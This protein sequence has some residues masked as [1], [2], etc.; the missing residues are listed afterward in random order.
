SSLSSR[1]D[2]AHT[3]RLLQDAPAAYRTQ[4][5]DLLLTALARV[6]TRWTGETS[7]LVQLEGHGREDLFDSID[8]TRTVGWFTS[9]FP[10]KL[11]PQASLADSIKFI[12][13]QLRAV[14]NKG[15]GFGALRYLGD[16]QA[17]QTLAALAVPR[18]TFNYLGQFDGSF[19]EQ[20][21]LF[22]PSG[23]AKGDDQ[24]PLAPL[25]NWLSLDGQVY[26]GELSLSWT[27]SQQM[28]D[29]AT[30]QRLADDYAEELK[31]LVAH[32]CAPEQAGATPS[33]FPLAGLNQQ[34]L[35]RLPLSLAAVEDL[36]PLSPMQ[37]GMLFHTLYEQA[38][39]DY[40]N[41]LRVDVDGLD[42]LRFQQAWQA[43]I[44]RHDILRTGFIWQGEVSTPL[45][46]V[47]KHVALDCTVHDWR[48]QPQ[49]HEALETLAE[50]ERQRGFELDAVP[51]LRLTLVRTDEQRYHLIYTNHHILMDGWSNSQ[52]L[53]E[54]LQR[55]AGQ[56]PSHAPG[57]YRDYIAWLQRQDAQA[58][59]GFWKEQLQT[60]D[61]PTRLTQA[62][63]RVA[64]IVAGT[65]HGK[66][67][68]ELDLAQTARLG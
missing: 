43:A 5:N 45:Q 52:L 68:R 10:V 57:R 1:L 40:I 21:S 35:D 3:Q 14:P 12:K 32:C 7:A 9:L 59:E 64:D 27:F 30:V 19:D 11:T 56:A 39:G 24:S 47:H 66:H 25:S 65:G 15:I 16:A 26:G 18:I 41:Q 22:K 4:I 62:L 55:Y 8:L 53:G 58:C 44:D 33:D 17:Q 20:D 46:V 67:H 31:A 34:Q 6:I 60:L 29:T 54:V 2:K 51:L 23:E 42:P 37:Q 50:A 49:Q 61:E 48:G 28:F 36:Y 63:S 13:E 38:A